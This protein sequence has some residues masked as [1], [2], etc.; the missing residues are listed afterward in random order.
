NVTIIKPT[1][2]GNVIGDLLSKFWWFELTE[3]ASSV[4]NAYQ[5]LT[6]K[7]NSRLRQG[8]E[9]DKLLP[10]LSDLLLYEY[11][12]LKKTSKEEL[13]EG[14]EHTVAEVG[15]M[16]L[17]DFASEMKEIEQLSENEKQ[18]ETKIRS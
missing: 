11:S 9:I 4:A 16:C 18:K 5:T 1:N 2:V 17:F 14:K 12:K 7:I 3:P 15:K 6:T 10:C 13:T 8:V